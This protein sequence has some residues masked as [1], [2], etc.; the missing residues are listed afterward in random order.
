ME[1]RKK[2]QITSSLIISFRKYIIHLTTD[3]SSKPRK[4]KFKISLDLRKHGF[5]K[6]KIES[7]DLTWHPV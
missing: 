7:E 5:K 2:K 4:M 1:N 6:K 3:N